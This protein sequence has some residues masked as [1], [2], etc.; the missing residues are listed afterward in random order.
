MAF[1]LKPDEPVLRGLRRVVRKELRSARNELRKAT[2]PGD[3]A[4]H[5]AR[6]SLKKVR[7]VVDL[8]AADDGRGLADCENRVR[9]INRKLSGLRDA[10]AVVAMLTKLKKKYPATFDEHTFAR[11]RRRLSSNKIAVAGAAQRED[12]WTALDRELRLLRRQATRWR[13]VDRGFDALA[14][15]IHAAHRRGRKALATARERQRADDFHAWRKRIKTLWYELRL[16]EACGPIIQ[17]DVRAL[18]QAEACLGDDHNLVLLCAALRLDASIGDVAPV[19]F[20]AERYQ[21][22][23]RRKALEVAARVYRSHPKI[24]LRRVR[25][26]WRQWRLQHR[27]DDPKIRGAAA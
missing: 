12:L 16:L 11:L 21:R 24:Y 1:R 7:A 22:A 3:E 23:L 25:R 14:S 8:V 4:I 27:R 15:G 13:P 6:K 18:R 5:E 20:A 17:D 26:A 9:R 19:Q 10:E 2:P